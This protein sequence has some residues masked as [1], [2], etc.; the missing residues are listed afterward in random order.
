MRTLSSQ[1]FDNARNFIF[2][3][4]SALLRQRW[5]ESFDRPNPAGVLRALA[6]YQNPD[7]GFGHNLEGDFT[8][9]AS[10]PMATSV[11]FQILT[12]MDAPVDEPLVQGGIAYLLQTYLPERPGWI[13]VPPEVNDHPHAPW[14]HYDPR[15]GGSVIDLSW[16]NPTAELVG[17]LARYRSLV[18][19]VV[20][21][22]L[23]AYTLKYF[24]Q[25]TGEMNMHELYCF[26]R[27]AEQLPEDEAQAMQPKLTD[28]VLQAVCLDPAE[29]GG[30]CAQPL[31]FV[32]S[33]AS[34]LY[35]SLAEAV[36]VNLDD[37]IDRLSPEGIA[38]VPWE[39]ENYPAEWA[40]QRPEI[41]GR[42]ALKNLILLK[43]FD[44]LG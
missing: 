26:L 31:D 33:P 35:S 10:S 30:Y 6:A 2:T 36:Q 19:T 4:G 9:P 17:Y 32:S 29:W 1:T 40:A 5:I 11:A 21:E 22:P 3:H 12:A 44:R 28:F 18:P 16:G 13:S 43:R 20:F 41:E 34:F 38:P 39:W 14:W 24:R 37:R 7:G 27:L 15:Q 42:E 8:L 23:L 25:F